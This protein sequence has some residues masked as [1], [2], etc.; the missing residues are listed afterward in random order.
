VIA[1]GLALLVNALLTPV[2]I[3][4]L[5]LFG[6]TVLHLGGFLG[7][8]WSRWQGRRQFVLMSTDA[9]GRSA[10]QI[11]DESQARML[12]SL[13]IL[14]LGIRLG[15][16]LGLA[17]T[18]IPLGPAL[19]AFGNGDAHALSS[20]LAIAFHATVI[21]LAIGGVNFTMQLLRRRWYRLDLIDIRNA[22][23]HEPASRRLA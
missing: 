7:E 21:G 17:G 22:C 3:A 2:L 20:Q 4:I 19:V 6:F 23:L 16:V 11:V 9:R 15:P 10:E 1:H 13:E 18:L 14:A 12:H 8:C 5:V